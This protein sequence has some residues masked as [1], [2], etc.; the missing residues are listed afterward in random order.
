MNIEFIYIGIGILATLIIITVISAFI[1]LFRTDSASEALP[2][3][4]KYNFYL[5]REQ[6]KTLLNQANQ[7]IKKSN[8]ANYFKLKMK[9]LTA[10]EKTICRGL[11]FFPD[12]Q[13]GELL[14]IKIAKLRTEN[15]VKKCNEMRDLI[16]T[17][18]TK[19]T[20]NKYQTF[21]AKIL[22]NIKKLQKLYPH[23]RLWKDFYSE[24]YIQCISA[25]T[26]QQ[27]KDANKAVF[28]HQYK[29]AKKHYALALQF[30]N[31]LTSDNRKIFDK[32]EKKIKRIIERLKLLS[33][34]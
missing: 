25:K 14:L 28:K 7:E 13:E 10:A 20:L 9:A 31:S 1:K 16:K 12:N 30:I 6:Y 3:R 32:T 19:M 24:V 33:E 22:S 34:N 26:S 2:K 5:L 17:K 21:T 29:T 4:V 8:E 23:N 15:I 27:L 11:N 18:K